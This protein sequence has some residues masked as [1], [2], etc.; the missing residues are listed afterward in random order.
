M[1]SDGSVRYNDILKQ[2][3]TGGSQPVASFI[4]LLNIPAV[5]IRIPNPD[6]YIHGP[7]ENINVQNFIEGV[8]ISLG[9]LT[10]PYE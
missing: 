4:N 3:T 7:N 8:K 9:I 6:N 10:E 2:S 1:W 5:S